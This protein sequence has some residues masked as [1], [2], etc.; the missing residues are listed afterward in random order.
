MVSYIIPTDLFYTYQPSTIYDLYL[1]ILQNKEI[2]CT[3]LVTEKSLKT[4]QSWGLK[5]PKIEIE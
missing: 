3:V 1:N 4:I 5:Y 2:N